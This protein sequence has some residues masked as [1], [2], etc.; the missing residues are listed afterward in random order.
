MLIIRVVGV[1]FEGR[2]AKITRLR[3]E[4][5]LLL[6]PEDDNPHDPRAVS[7]RTL[8]GE[9]LGFVSRHQTSPVREHIKEHGPKCSV[10]EAGGPPERDLPFLVVKASAKGCSTT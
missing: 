2:A 9:M 3:P 10:V 1:T 8:A 7:I 6:K 5:E 4:D